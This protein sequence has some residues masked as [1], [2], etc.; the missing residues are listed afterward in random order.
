MFFRFRSKISN[1][2]LFYPA[3]FLTAGYVWCK[4]TSPLSPRFP[5][6]FPIDN[7][8]TRVPYSQEAFCRKNGSKGICL[9]ASMYQVTKSNSEEETQAAILHKTASELYNAEE[10]KCKEKFDATQE[11]RDMY[12]S[13][14]KMVISNLMEKTFEIKKEDINVTVV[15]AK[16][17]SALELDEFYSHVSKVTSK[18]ESDT[19]FTLVAFVDVHSNFTGQYISRH[20]IRFDLL[21]AV[22]YRCSFYDSNNALIEGSCPNVEK[23]FAQR[24]NYYYSNRVTLFRTPSLHMPP[25]STPKDQSA[26]SQQKS[27]SV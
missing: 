9:G 26:Q 20:A 19:P 12:D 24:L 18:K 1:E 11:N 16:G 17:T 25:L 10:E 13:L 21:D 7:T 2:A 14:E 8:L 3:L 6:Y 5:R 27:P 23:A 15:E 22:A 4:A